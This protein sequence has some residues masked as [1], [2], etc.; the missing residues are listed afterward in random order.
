[1][2]YNAGKTLS[3]SE[4]SSPSGEAWSESSPAHSPL[5]PSS[6]DVIDSFPQ[7]PQRDGDRLARGHFHQGPTMAKR[8][9]GVLLS[10]DG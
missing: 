3:S 8:Q 4:V 10:Q 1:M 7:R 2:G 9:F 6:N 5:V